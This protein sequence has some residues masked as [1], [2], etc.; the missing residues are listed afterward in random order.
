MGQRVSFSKSLATTVCTTADFPVLANIFEPEDTPLVWSISLVVQRTTFL[1]GRWGVD[2]RLASC[3]M[4]TTGPPRSSDL[5]Y[6]QSTWYTNPRSVPETRCKSL[7]ADTPLMSPDMRCRVVAMSGLRR[8]AHLYLCL[9]IHCEED[10]PPEVA[11]IQ[12]IGQQPRLV[13][14]TRFPW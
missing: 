14:S 3:Y 2:G 9:V 7:L 6:S 11:L 13:Q 12:K 4:V 5:G 10:I 1:A 8:L